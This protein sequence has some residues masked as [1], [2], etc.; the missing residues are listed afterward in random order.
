MDAPRISRHSAVVGTVLWIVWQWF[1]EPFA[2]A[3]LF[4]LS[5]LVLV[6]LLLRPL[7]EHEVSPLL[8]ALV[9]AQLPCALLLPVAVQ[10]HTGVIAMLAVLPWLG[11]TALLAVEALQRLAALVRREGLVGIVRSAEL[12]VIA[13]LGFPVIGAGWLMLD[14]LDIQPFG[15][16][17]LIVLLTAVHFH[18]AGFTLPLSAGYLGRVHPHNRILRAAALTIVFSVPLVAIGIT[19]SPVIEV[20]GAWLTAGSAIV[21]AIGMLERVRVSP[22]VPALLFGVSGACLLAGMVF[23]ASYSLSEFLAVPWPDI[24]AMVDLH[25]VVNALGFGLLGAWAW[26]LSPLPNHR[27]Q[28]S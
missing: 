27:P 5:P 15:F 11:W 18:H 23:A 17:P 25:G 7:V 1:A 13:G 28:S 2:V 9:W 10:L 3:A 8:R 16:S 4:A 19:W 12:A 26:H 21:V 22:I 24:M 20:I 14:R 6:P